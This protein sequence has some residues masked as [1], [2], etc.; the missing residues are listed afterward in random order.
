MRKLLIVLSVVAVA[1]IVGLFIV[2]SM[3]KGPDLSKYES[4]KQPQ[5][6]T[7]ENQKVIEVEAMGDPNVVGREAFGLLIKTYFKTKGLPKGRNV[8]AP[9]GRWPVSAD[10]PKSEWVGYYAM[11]VPETVT[12]IPGGKTKTG[13][14][15]KLNT[16]EYGEVAEILHIGPY[17]KEQPTV[18]KLLDFVSASGYT[19]VGLHE[20]E[21]LRG[22]TMF[23]KGDPAKY[24]TII[25]YRVEKVEPAPGT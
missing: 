6:R 12:Q 1:L 5:I 14:T 7:M 25:R 3:P 11:P 21:Y 20:E 18:K 15:A 19:V 2:V 22:P 8:P 13:L 9:R 4:L 23:S 24:A 16:W 10:R 17:D